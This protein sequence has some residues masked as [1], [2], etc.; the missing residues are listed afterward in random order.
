MSIQMRMVFAAVVLIVVA[1]GVWLAFLYRA[2][3]NNTVTLVF[4]ARVGDQPLVFNK[5]NYA[6]PGGPGEF[7]IRDFRFYISNIKLYGAESEHVEPNSYHL[8]RFDNEQT[9]FSIVLEDVV[10]NEINKIRLSIGVDPP[11]NSSIEPVGD[12]DPNSKMAWNWEV[13]YKFVLLEGVI[14]INNQMHPLVYHIGF[15]E[16]RR[17]LEFDVPESV[18]L[19]DGKKLHFAVDVMKLFM[20]TSQINIADIQSVKFDKT[21]ARL[22]ANN[23]QKMII[24]TWE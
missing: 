24:A 15:E 21:D 10:L 5:Y 12:L 3:Q 17:D 6:N 22:F 13:G 11:A 14:R 19:S 8:A 1:A 23:Y 4:K 7:K 18:S 9:A 20:G 16:N 2:P